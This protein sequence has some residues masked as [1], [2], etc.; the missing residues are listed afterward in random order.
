[1][2]REKIEVGGYEL[3]WSLS[4]VWINGADGCSV[5]RFS[6]FGIDIHKSA[7]SQVATGVACLVCTHGKPTPDEWDHFLVLV[8]DRFGVVIPPRAR[9]AWLPL[10]STLGE[11]M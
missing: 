8:K 4:H 11:L 9:P 3:S 10:P 5:A 7:A 2:M 6:P 1:M